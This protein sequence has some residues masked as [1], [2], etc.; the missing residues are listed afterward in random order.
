MRQASRA[1]IVKDDKILLMERNKFGL[2]YRALIGGGINSGENA[3]DA[4]HREVFEEASIRIKNPKLVITE[5]AGEIYGI[6]YIFL[7]EYDGGEV[8]LSPDSEEY[9]ISAM[10]KNTY[11]PVW[12]PIK[13]LKEAHILPVELN[14]KLIEFTTNGFPSEPI[15]LKIDVT[16]II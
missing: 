9:G 1:I 16:N 2:K 12:F 13:D 4:L 5:D 15:Q 14:D 8:K 11:N 3:I 7:V 6:Q 10:G